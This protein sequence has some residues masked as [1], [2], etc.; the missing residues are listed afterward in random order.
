MPVPGEWFALPLLEAAGSTRTGG[1]I[2]NNYFHPVAV[3]LVGHCDVVLRVGGA[4]LGTYE[5]VALRLSRGKIIFTDFS[6]IPEV[7]SETPD[8][9]LI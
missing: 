4:S 6:D 3:R 8:I 1:V 7:K 5:M 9:N 2:F